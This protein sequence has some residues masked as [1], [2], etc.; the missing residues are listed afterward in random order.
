MNLFFILFLQT[1]CHADGATE[2]SQ[3]LI[4]LRS[5]MEKEAQNLESF[6][7]SLDQQIQALQGQVLELNQN[8]SREKLKSK[9]LAEKTKRLMSF[10]NQGPTGTLEDQKFVSQWIEDL[11]VWV[12]GSLPFQKQQ[13]LSKLE[14]LSSRFKKKEPLEPLVWDLWSFTSLELKNTKGFSN[15]VAQINLDGKLVTA[16]IAKLGMV[17]L[18][19]KTTDQKMGYALK[20]KQGWTFQTA[21]SESELN[22]IDHIMKASRAKSFK[23]VYELPGLKVQVGAK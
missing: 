22:A 9:V 1:V 5:Q 4:P 14:E 10:T 7:Q 21:H 11:K 17:H 20:S 18:Y 13:R 16:E 15:E 6:Q 2:L 19:F 12:D 8:L 3:Q 23:N